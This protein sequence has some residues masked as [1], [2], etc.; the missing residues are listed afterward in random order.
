MQHPG[1]DA[2]LSTGSY[3]SNV[4]TLLTFPSALEFIYPED[5]SSFTM[6]FSKNS[7]AWQAEGV[8]PTGALS[9][10][11][12]FLDI[13]F[14][15]NLQK[16]ERGVSK[17]AT[18]W[19]ESDKWEYEEGSIKPAVQVRPFKFWKRQI[20]LSFFNDAWYMDLAVMRFSYMQLNVFTP[21]KRYMDQRYMAGLSP[22]LTPPGSCVQEW[23]VYWE[24]PTQTLTIPGR[25]RLLCDL[26]YRRTAWLREQSPEP[27]R[28]PARWESILWQTQEKH[29]PHGCRKLSFTITHFM[30]CTRRLPYFW[31]ACLYFPSFSTRV[32]SDASFYLSN[33]KNGYLKVKLEDLL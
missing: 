31:R 1:F 24:I 11:E 23:L 2:V 21:K 7:G 32:T 5:G 33:P 10:S 22:I 14:R 17:A 4:W 27:R 20:C 9:S 25:S 12:S 8:C 15:R 16:P 3:C 26:Q 18:F 30:G 29:A 19:L 6:C 13:W 28:I